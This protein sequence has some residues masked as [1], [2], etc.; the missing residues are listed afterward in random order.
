VPKLVVQAGALTV[1][2]KD[3]RVEMDKATLKAWKN[4]AREL[5]EG[6]VDALTIPLEE[7]GEDGD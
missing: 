5:I 1:L 6:A 2:I 4:A 3:D 7:G